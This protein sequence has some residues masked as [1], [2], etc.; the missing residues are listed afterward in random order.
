MRGSS[1]RMTRWISVLG[2]TGLSSRQLALALL[3]LDHPNLID[4]AIRGHRVAVGRH[5]HV[6]H[7]VAAAGYRPALEFLRLG[8]E[9]HDGVR[10]GAGL[11]VPERAFGEDD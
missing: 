2:P 10:L 6:A 5:A 4:Q 8:I 3:H 7:D 9:A 1:P 11:V